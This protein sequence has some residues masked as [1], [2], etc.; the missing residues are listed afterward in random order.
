MTATGRPISMSTFRNA[1]HHWFKT[2]TGIPTIWRD[3]SAP[4]PSYPF[5]SLLITTGPEQVSPAWEQ[6]ISFD[7][8][9]P[10]GE[11]VEILIHVPCR[12]VVSCQAFV[13][14]PEARDPDQNAVDYINRAKAALG[15]PSFRSKQYLEDDRPT[16]ESANI[17]V[18]GPGPVLNL[19]ELIEDAYISRANMDVAFGASLSLAEYT[20]YIDKAQIV[21]A[22]LG[23]DFVVDAS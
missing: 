17:A 21:S 18:I 15:L 1:V 7:D 6:R 19:D 13:G 22:D 11:E 3:Q 8:G 20:G 16:F 5:G 2:A 14:M 23:I 4:Q 12:F 10:A 9:R